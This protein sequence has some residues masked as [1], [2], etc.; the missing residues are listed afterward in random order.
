M[1]I[2]RTTISIAFGVVAMQAAFAL[3]LT[4]RVGLT[5][6]DNQI[7]PSYVISMAGNS[8]L[9][10]SSQS[11]GEV[12]SE[13]PDGIVSVGLVSESSQNVR[14]EISSG[15][16]IRKSVWEGTVEKDKPYL[17]RPLI[18]WNYDYL[19]RL[20]QP[21]VINIEYKAFVDGKQVLSKKAQARVRSINDV[22]F[23]YVK[24][25]QF[26]SLANFFAAYVNENHP[27]IDTILKEALKTGQVD[28]FDGYQSGDP[29]K[30]TQQVFAIWNVM[31][32]LGF[33]YSSITTS[34]GSSPVIYSQYVRFLDQSLKATQAN[35]VD[36]TILFS[37]ILRKIGIDPF[38]VLEPSHMYLGYYLDSNHK[39]PTLLETTAMGIV[40]LKEFSD[41]STVLGALNVIMGAD[42]KDSASAKTFNN[43]VEIARNRLI[44]NKSNYAQHKLGYMSVDIKEA[45]DSGINPINYVGE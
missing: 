1:N 37:S 30:V 7:F 44:A 39:M 4:P 25:N 26:V 27:W 5:G 18:D 11:E 23:G 29:Q 35:C 16:V 31:Q 9:A 19:N 28:S 22:A 14:V 10:S 8:P 43:A 33:K 24:N 17:I 3:E 36:G 40:N 41:D 21:T 45:R 34:S 20:N 6:K 32:K 2:I 15:D 12:V 42:S 13:S 38:L